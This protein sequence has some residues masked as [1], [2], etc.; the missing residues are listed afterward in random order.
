[1]SDDSHHH[2]GSLLDCSGM[3]MSCIGDPSPGLA[4]AVLRGFFQAAGSASPNA[5]KDT[6]G[7]LD[8][9]AVLKDLWNIPDG[10]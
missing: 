8:R 7:L 5:A 4:S 6:V 3:S 1:M 9:A 2:Y 10:L